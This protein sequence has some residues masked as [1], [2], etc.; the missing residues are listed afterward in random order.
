MPLARTVIKEFLA[1]KS[2]YWRMDLEP[3]SRRK[4]DTAGGSRMKPLNFIRGY[5]RR[6]RTVRLRYRLAFLACKVP[7][8]F[9]L[10]LVSCGAS[11]G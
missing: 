4:A 1:I 2:M 9:E 3:H 10:M 8:G 11:L 6:V 5:C 7:S